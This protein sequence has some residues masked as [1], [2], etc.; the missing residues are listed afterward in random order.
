MTV[1]ELLELLFEIRSKDVPDPE[2]VTA[3]LVS[4]GRTDAL[5]GRTDLPLACGSLVGGV[6]KAVGRKNQAGFL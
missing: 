1:L 3:D 6:Q 5:Q 4:V 2:S